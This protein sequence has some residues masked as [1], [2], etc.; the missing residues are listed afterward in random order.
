MSLEEKV[1]S[2]KEQRQTN[3][4]D[5]HR[6]DH[7]LQLDHWIYWPDVLFWSYWQDWTRPSAGNRRLANR[8]WWRFS[9]VARNLPIDQREREREWTKRPAW[10]TH[11]SW[12]EKEIPINIFTFEMFVHE[13]NAKATAIHDLVHRW[14]EIGYIRLEERGNR[15]SSSSRLLTKHTWDF[16][17]AYKETMMLVLVFQIIC[18]KSL[19]VFTIGCWVM[20]NSSTRW[21]P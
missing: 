18:Q 6:R 15:M 17:S 10:R 3:L 8:Y 7:G 9:L 1:D 14:P 21:H 2:I 12:L 20:M 13:T 11:L 5:D 16:S 4:L 19:I